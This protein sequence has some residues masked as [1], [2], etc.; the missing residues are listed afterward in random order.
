MLGLITA[1]GRTDL[2]WEIAITALICFLGD[3]IRIYRRPHWHHMMVVEVIDCEHVRVIH[4][5]GELNARAV[6]AAASSMTLSSAAII[7][8][9]L[10]IRPSEKDTVELL[11]YPVGE[12][13]HTGHQAVARARS[14]LDERKYK[15]LTNN[16]EHFI[17]WA[18]TE[19]SES[20][21]VAKAV[22]IGAGVGTAAAVTVGVFGV[23]AII[24]AVLYSAFGGGKK[25]E[26]D[27]DSD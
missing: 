8:E 10:E 6:S 3:H 23:G 25:E 15:L 4:Y 22:K 9:S 27:S 14:R 24:G 2:R 11:H 13:R 19:K 16:C 20:G 17:N 7:E 21:Q 12:E 26:E 18:I 5:K 1:T